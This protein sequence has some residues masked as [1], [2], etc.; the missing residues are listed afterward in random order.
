MYSQRS[1]SR[2]ACWAVALLM[3]TA[4]A[5]D[6][7]EVN[8]L[9]TA[10]HIDMGAYL[11]D[12][13]MVYTRLPTEYYD[14]LILGN[15]VMGALV[16]V[17]EP[18][19]LV[20]LVT[21]SDAYSLS[22]EVFPHR[23]PIGRFVLETGAAID[24]LPAQP[25]RVRIFDGLLEGTLRTGSGEIEIRAFIEAEREVLTVLTRNTGSASAEWRFEGDADPQPTNLG[26][27][28]GPY[29]VGPFET[30]PPAT[31]RERGAW[32]FSLAYTEAGQPAGDVT[33]AWDEAGEAEW[34]VRNATIAYNRNRGID[35]R[36]T[37]LTT[38]EAARARGVETRL[39]RHIEVWNEFMSR[40]F[41]SIPEKKLESFYYIQYH[42]VRGAT[43][44]GGNLIDLQATWFDP[45]SPWPALWTNLNIQLAY[46]LLN[47][48]NA[49]ELAE[50]LIRSVA[51]NRQRF[52]A[53]AGP[54]EG[55]YALTG[56]TTPDFIPPGPGESSVVLYEDMP[57]AFRR[58]QPYPAVFHRA[59]FGNFLWLCHNLWL[60]H[61]YTMDEALLRETLY[62]LLAGGVELY[63][64]VIREGEGGQLHLPVMYSPEYEY[65][66][67]ANYDL[68][69][70]KWA[71]RVLLE[72]AQ[73]ADG[74]SDGRIR[75]WRDIAAR[76]VDYPYDAVE[77]YTIG[78]GVKL[79]APHRHF[80]HLMMI[81]P[82]YDVHVEQ[83]GG[84]E[85]IRRSVDFWLS[86]VED[87]RAS[88]SEVAVA[89][90]SF[91]SAASMYAAMGDAGQAWAYLDAFVDTYGG[92]DISRGNTHYYAHSVSGMTQEVS[93][94]GAVSLND[95]LLQSWGGKLRVFPAVPG[96]WEDAAFAS[97]RGEGAFLVSAE[98]RSGELVRLHI[99]SLA[100]A[101]C[102]VKAEGLARLAAAAPANGGRLEFVGEDEAVCDLAAGEE[103][104]L[105]APQAAQDMP[106]VA[107]DG[108]EPA[109][110][111]GLK[112]P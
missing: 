82:F 15:G 73:D 70:L 97:L 28:V 99:G 40:R 46:W 85:K 27:N 4:G 104:L 51:S 106:A 30:A 67:D 66:P 7:R 60:I 103:L 72:H 110:F 17:E 53:M 18:N 91:T 71:V 80:S 31:G 111:F 95:M 11:A 16:Y 101:P 1:A 24:L 59:T 78:A 3:A 94:A 107:G 41:V 64:Q 22:E 45:R 62:P 86:Y 92:A 42:K 105:T 89:G 102:R 26:R 81:Y 87:I 69:V 25:F 112:R 54:Y 108:Q 57:E 96:H 65:A 23:K 9:D 90:Y 58:D 100:G 74:V 19:R 93:L 36:D 79:E 61:R 2:I 20:F 49:P 13:D 43:R 44:P 35:T 109:N 12:H 6:F 76:L 63:R 8:A 10:A 68:T 50:P 77:G 37:A 75:E 55:G 48:G 5:Q 39:D 47:T 21:R 32:F 33:V 52:A 84:L 88:H 38:L 98:R 56:R 29:F 83:P 34:T 14:G